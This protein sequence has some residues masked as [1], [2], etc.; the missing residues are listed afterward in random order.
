MTEPKAGGLDGP[1]GSLSREIGSQEARRLLARRPGAT[2]IWSG[3]GMFGLIGWSVAGPT[4]LGALLGMWLD[5]HHS[6]G[7]SWTLA[8][9]VAGLCLGIMSAWHWVA[10]EYAQMHAAEE[11]KG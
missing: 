7:H 1:R 2:A 5:K 11:R 3:F 4:L 9:L 6:G 8:L 10:K